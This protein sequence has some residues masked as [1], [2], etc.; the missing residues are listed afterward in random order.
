MQVAVNYIGAFLRKT[1]KMWLQ[2]PF[3]ILSLKSGL[4]V[5]ADATWYG[6][7]PIQ[8]HKHLSQ[9]SLK[10]FHRENIN[11]VSYIVCM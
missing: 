3:P 7:V 10:K 5:A 6:L 11:F 9:I 8:K 1:P 2:K 4:K